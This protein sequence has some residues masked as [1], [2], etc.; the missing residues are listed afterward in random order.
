MVSKD[1]QPSAIRSSRLAAKRHA[2]RAVLFALIAATCGSSAATDVQA[3][4][5]TYLLRAGRV[6]T[7]TSDAQWVIPGGMILVQ[8]GKIA[9]VGADLVPPPFVDVIDMPDAVVMPGLVSADSWIAGQNAGKDSVG[10]HY[11]AIDAFD[12]YSNFDRILSGGVTTVYLNPGRHRLVSG[13]GAVVKLG[14][15]GSAAVLDETTD[16]VIN[17]GDPAFNPPRKPNWL[18]P[19]SSDLKIEPDTMQRPSSRLTQF[20]E[21]SESFDAAVKYADARR[22]ARASDRPDF[23]IGLDSLSE[24]LRRKALLRIRADRAIDIRQAVA[25]CTERKHAFVL[26]GAR[27]A[28]QAAVVLAEA[29]A[30]IV[31]EM[32]VNPSASGWDIGEAADALPEEVTIPESL[33]NL[34]I[35][36]V[37]PERAPHGELM[38]YASLARRGG[39][40]L[41]KAL[42]SVTSNAA[43]ILGVDAR[44]GS[45]QTGRDADFIILNGEPLE[46]TTHVRRVYVNGRLRFD[47][48]RVAADKLV[49]RAGRVWTGE[50]W[51]D[52]GAVLIENGRVVSAGPTAPVPPFARVIDAGPDAVLTPGFID[53][54]GHL[55]FEGDRSAAAGDVSIA[56]A[57]YGALPEFDRVC[58]SGVTTVFSSAYRP[59]GNGA[60]I[61]AIHTAGDDPDTLIVKETAGLLMAIGGPDSEAS[62]NRVRSAL[63][64]GKK[65]D[66][67][68]KK[69]EKELAEY[70]V[71]GAP[72]EEEKKEP[73][74]KPEEVTTEKPPADPITGTWEGEISGGPLPEP[75]Q[76]LAKLKLSG[77]EVEGSLEAMFGGGESVGVK[78]TFRDKHLSL[79]IDVEIPIGRAMI[80]MDVTREDFMTGYIDIAGRFRF[81]VEAKRTEKT[82]PEIK[83]TRKRA[84]KTDKGP[85]A[86]KKDES[87]EPYRE[88][89]AGRIALVLDVDTKATIEAVLPIFEKDFKVPFVL[90]NAVEASRTTEKIAKSG[91]G[92]ILRTELSR[93]RNRREEVQSVDLSRAGIPI[94]FQSDAEDAARQLPLRALYAMR[95]GLDETAALRALTGD[96]A[97]M[98]RADDAVGYLKSGCRGDVLIFDGPPLSPGTRLVRIFVDGKEVGR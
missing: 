92:V 78:G 50:A 28:S 7:M 95:K 86:P 39:L 17:V 91:V 74:K 81:D 29:K 63:T 56:R 97:K 36:V 70:L 61:S 18:V 4:G 85:E 65:Y 47:A 12:P 16:L 20:L 52:N 45:I 55:G 51:I 10:P 93:T 41:R 22:A 72:K 73:E 34:P 60:R 8:D 25:F 31:F 19:P 2:S 54:R 82:V 90:L 98:M 62:A 75:Q 88:L 46:A 33:H 5:P 14:A 1:M 42:E 96:A 80:E 64:A 24:Q 87:L 40:P 23:D 89:F 30:S 32:P 43:K 26:T 59:G 35:A 68:W 58:R 6:Y 15:S 11:R 38:L 27:E 48:D 66:D 77:E 84:R 67:A 83:I 13:V 79:E 57:L 3:A 9:A 21:L 44:V 76:F 71:K 69:Y 94:A 37:G 53:A 49:I